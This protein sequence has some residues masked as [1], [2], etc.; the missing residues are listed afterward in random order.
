MRKIL[1]AEKVKKL[2]VGTQVFFIRDATGQQGTLSVVKCGRKKILKGTFVEQEIKERPGW[3][4]EV[5][6]E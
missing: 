4:Y 3:H 5:E 6:K 1:T 2:P